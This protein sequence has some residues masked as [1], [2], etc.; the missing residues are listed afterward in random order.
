M[1]KEWVTLSLIGELKTYPL[2]E[3][4]TMK[5]DYCIMCTNWDKM[6]HPAIHHSS[7]QLHWT[8]QGHL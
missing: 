4:M 3:R 7:N 6:Y 1:N 5:R 8:Q 2:S